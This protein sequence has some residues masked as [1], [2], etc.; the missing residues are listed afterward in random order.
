MAFVAGYLVGAVP[1]GLL[2]TR[3]L[4]GIDIRRY[5][6]GNTGA[7]NVLHNVGLLPAAAVALGIFLQGLLPPLAARL[8]GASEAAVALAAL[9]AVAGYNWSVFLGFGAE[10]ARGVGVSTGAAAVVF[11]L[12]LIPLLSMYA[13]GRLLR[14]MAPGVLAGFVAYAAGAFYLEI[15]TADRI[16]ALLLLALLI[17]RR[18]EGV[19]QDLEQGRFVGVVLDRVLFDRRPG[20][21]LSGLTNEDRQG[22]RNKGG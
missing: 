17:L 3:E 10:G 20:Q 16:T 15:P 5:G 14:Q 11:P 2:V 12:G 21:R 9:G 4:Y 8:L 1:L 6:T 18:L 19:S 13:L 22:R 7:S